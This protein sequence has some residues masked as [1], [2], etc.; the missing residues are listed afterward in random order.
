M[1]PG[2]LVYA[3]AC[4]IAVLYVLAANIRG[5]VPF[6]TALGASSTGGPRFTGTAGHFHK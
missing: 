1:R 3:V 5:Y 6:T 2:P 4:G